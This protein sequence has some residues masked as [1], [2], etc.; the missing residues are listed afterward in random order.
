MYKLLLFALSIFPMLSFSQSRK[1]PFIARTSHEVGATLSSN[2]S[3]S[4]LGLTFNQYW[5]FGKK[6]KNFKVGVGARL[7]SSYG[8]NSLEYITAPARL[9]SGKTGPAVFF[10]DQIEKNIDTLSLGGTQVNSLNLYLALRYDFAKKWGVEFNID[11]AGVSI[12]AS[13]NAVL[14]Y[15]DQTHSTRAT[16]AK[17]SAGNL[18]L[19]SDNDLGSLNSE[20]MVSYKIKHNLKLKV[21]VVFLFNEYKLDNPVTYTNSLGTKVDAETYRTK[22]YMFGV[23]VN[24]IFKNK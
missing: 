1:I 5:G 9:T 2:G 21:G 24:Y 13:K 17:P 19:V 7:S 3:A 14:Q 22:M 16:T 15:G 20:L 10:A 18:L 12:G 8:S 11:M 23:G 4:A 6:K